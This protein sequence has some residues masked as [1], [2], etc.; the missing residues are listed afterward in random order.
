MSTAATY[1]GKDFAATVPSKDMQAKND[2]VLASVLEMGGGTACKGYLTEPII[3]PE[4]AGVVIAL[5]ASLPVVYGQPRD[6]RTRTT[7]A[8]H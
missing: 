8:L 7:D 1:C 5:K 2:K 3:T 4:L 6:L